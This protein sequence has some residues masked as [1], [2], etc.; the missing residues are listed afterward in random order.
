VEVKLG[1]S[2]SL[3]SR[4]FWVGALLLVL[5]GLLY[6][7]SEIA[8]TRGHAGAPGGDPAIAAVSLM[9]GLLE[10][11]GSTC[12]ILSALVSIFRTVHPSKPK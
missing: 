6:G 4:L 10:F 3:E 7:V 9:V 12:L 2:G 8:A 5:T 1:S 11:A